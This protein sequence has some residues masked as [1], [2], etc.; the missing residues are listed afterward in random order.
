MLSLRD[1]AHT[2]VAIS[3]I[4]RFLRL[5]GGLPHQESGLV[6]NDISYLGTSITQSFASAYFKFPECVYLFYSA[7][8]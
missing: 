2:V 8:R 1:S 3:R 4:F 5:T 7:A 6:R